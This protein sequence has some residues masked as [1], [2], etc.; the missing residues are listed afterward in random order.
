MC[1]ISG[2]INLDGKPVVESQLSAMMQ[3]MKHR[4]PDDNGM[5]AENGMGLGFV[6]LSILD[7]SPAGHQPMFSADERYV[8][9]FN[10]EI[11]NYIELREELI[12]LGRQF[13]TQSDSE[14]LLATYEQ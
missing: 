2:I 13:R 10:G 6:R 8:L 9:I 11:F 7:L 1:G 3:A 5:F 14:I 12:G 4:G